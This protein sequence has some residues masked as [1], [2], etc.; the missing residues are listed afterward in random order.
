MFG[1]IGQGQVLMIQKTNFQKW[2][3]VTQKM[4]IVLDILYKD[5]HTPNKK[6]FA[7]KYTLF[8]QLENRSGHGQI[9]ISTS[10]D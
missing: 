7:K 1:F 3:K 5:W 10:F 2:F 4:T 9:S 6:P 8:V